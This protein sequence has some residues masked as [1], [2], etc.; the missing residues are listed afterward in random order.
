MQVCNQRS[1]LTDVLQDLGGHALRSRWGFTACPLEI[2]TIESCGCFRTLFLSK[3]LTLYI[4]QLIVVVTTIVSVQYYVTQK[5]L[6][7]VK[8]NNKLEQIFAER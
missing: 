2:K 6:D 3:A 5:E 8:M 7:L 1:L 4:P